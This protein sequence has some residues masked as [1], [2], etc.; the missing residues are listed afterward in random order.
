MGEYPAGALA[1]FTVIGSHRSEFPSIIAI[2]SL[3]EP[4]TAIIVA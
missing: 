4:E 3:A 2:R 1:I